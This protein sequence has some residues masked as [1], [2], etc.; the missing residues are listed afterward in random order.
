MIELKRNPYPLTLPLWVFILVVLLSAITA[1]AAANLV[2]TSLLGERQFGITA[3]DLKPAACASINLHEVVYLR[4]TGNRNFLVL[5]SADNDE[6][7]G[8]SGS[9]C[10][11]GGAGND[12]LNGGG[13]QG[14]DI[15]LGGAGINTCVNCAVRIDCN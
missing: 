9:D 14:Y 15:C 3:N 12:T 4:G 13:G 11:V 7:R 1:T 5:G 10:L 8:S 2:P 6:L